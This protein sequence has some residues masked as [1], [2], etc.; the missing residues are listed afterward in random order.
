M[1]RHLAADDSHPAD[2]LIRRGSRAADRHVILDLANSVRVQESRD[3]DV[4]VGPI[5]LLVAKIIAGRGDAEPPALLVVEDRGE[6]ARRIEMRQAEPVDRAVHAD[7]GRGPHVADDAV[8]LDRLV[9]R[10]HRII[11]PLDQQPNREPPR[12]ILFTRL[13]WAVNLRATWL[14]RPAI[15]V[16]AITR[17]APFSRNDR[18]YYKK[19]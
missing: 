9:I 3:Q 18:S 15:A 14:S 19:T 2:E 17:N 10:C 11:P 12:L 1:E 4:G 5:E 13:A 7:Q 16:L 6:D 8:V